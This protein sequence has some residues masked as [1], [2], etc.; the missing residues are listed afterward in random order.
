MIRVSENHLLPVAHTG[1]INALLNARS[2]GLALGCSISVGL[3]LDV[4]P[5]GRDTAGDSE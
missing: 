4:V 3:R 1:L 5:T 2:A